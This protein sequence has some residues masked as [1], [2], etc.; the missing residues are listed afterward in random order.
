MDEQTSFAEKHSH[1][2]ILN[3]SVRGWIALILCIAL[4][5]SILI[6]VTAPFMN[7]VISDRVSDQLVAMFATGF[8]GAVTQYFHQ[9]SKEGQRIK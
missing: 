9:G 1:S 4:S 5:I 7:V 3:T 2:T 8:G 6:V